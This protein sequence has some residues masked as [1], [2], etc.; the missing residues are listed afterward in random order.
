M[1]AKLI[2]YLFIPYLMLSCY[3]QMQEKRDPDIAFKYYSRAVEQLQAKNY[4]D[5]LDYIDQAI[6]KNARIAKYYELRAEINFRQNL[7][8]DA[9][10]D[11]K[12]AVALR[13]FYPEAYINMGF[14]YQKMERYDDAIRSYRK[15]LAQ[16]PQDL[17][18]M[19]SIAD[20]YIQQNYLDIAQNQLNDYLTDVNKN[21][22]E[23]NREF[24]VLQAKINF[25]KGA[26]G[27]AVRNINIAKKYTPLN[28]NECLFYLRSLIETGAL[29]E[30]YTQAGQQ[31]KDILKESD[32]HFIRGLYYKRQNNLK[33]ARTQLELSVDKKTA[34]Y[35][36]YTLL[37][38]IYNIM[39]ETELEK[40]IQD[41]AD[42]L[43]NKRLINVE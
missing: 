40:E 43:S 28:R 8:D 15:A 35:E 29:E 2:T 18:L 30:A 9:I 26:F 39:G 38:E 33:D 34:I 25:E 24:Y 11:Y 17:Y 22:K 1:F 31:Y 19:L 5:A 13:S 4:P 21:K 7:Y 32:F 14:I 42:K 36:A 41:K 10:N 12:N 6:D 37:A 20:N 23:I 16:T 27:E 3:P